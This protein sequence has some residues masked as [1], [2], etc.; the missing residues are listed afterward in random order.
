MKR[1]AKD[2]LGIAYWQKSLQKNVDNK[3]VIAL[4]PDKEELADKTADDEG[5]EISEGG[6]SDCDA[7]VLHHLQKVSFQSSLRSH[8]PHPMVDRQVR[9]LLRES[10]QSIDQCEHVVDAQTFAQLFDQNRE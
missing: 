2:K 7:S 5:E 8:Q 9:L 1:Q 3:N 4:Q 6:D 10:L